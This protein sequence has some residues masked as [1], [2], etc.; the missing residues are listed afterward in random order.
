MTYKVEPFFLAS[1]DNEDQVKWDRILEDYFNLLITFDKHEAE[2]L[3]RIQYWSN[4]N[5]N[6]T[7]AMLKI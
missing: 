6:P 7:K 3:K 1:P 2:R 4:S 5:S